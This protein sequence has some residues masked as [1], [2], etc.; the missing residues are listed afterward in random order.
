MQTTPL[1]ESALS[2][3]DT[4]RFESADPSARIP[5]KQLNEDDFLKLLVTQ[6]QQQDPFKAADSAQ[7]M[8][9]FVA[10][11]NFQS[12][13]RMATEY[14][15]S[16]EIQSMATAS[17]LPGKT[18]Q[19]KRPDGS[20]GQGVV[21]ESWVKDGVVRFAIGTDE[22]NLSQVVG[23]VAPQSNASAPSTTPQPGP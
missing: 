1:P 6:L 16:S 5:A 10:L 13:Q 7:M 21:T 18:V 20:I 15:R 17:T 19:I 23:W 8:Q 11:G 9:Q 22:F 3:P 14:A 12:M 2:V 4:V